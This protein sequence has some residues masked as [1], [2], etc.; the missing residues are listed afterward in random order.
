MTNLEGR[1][2]R[3]RAVARPPTGVRERHRHPAR[4]RRPARVRREVRV[5]HTRERCSTSSAGRPPAAIAD[6][7]GI[8]YERI[9]R[10]DGVFW[11]CPSE[12]HPGT[13]RLF[14]E[15]F[16][17]AG[18]RARFF[19]VEHRPAGEEPDA[20]YPLYFTTGRYQEHYNSGAQTRLVG[21]ADDGRSRVPRLQTPPAAGPATS[22]SSTGSRGDAGE[23]PRAGRVRRRGDAGHPPG[24]AVRPVPLGRPAGGEPADEPRPRPDQPDARV[25][26]RRRP[27]RRGRG[28]PEDDA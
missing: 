18:R 12:D 23:P 10:E 22:A 28:P 13:P 17:H 3:R 14:A 6:Y 1:V 20:E 24:H 25:Q 8:T 15:R 2:I 21:A 26:A 5:P 7:C 27:H 19:A 9:D 11:P 4:T 16:H